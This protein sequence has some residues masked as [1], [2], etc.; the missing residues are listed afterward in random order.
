MPNENK[1]DLA[2]DL[3]ICEAATVG[4]WAWADGKREYND[5]GRVTSP[6]GDVCNF[7]N[8]ARYYPTAGE[9]PSKADATFIAEARTGWPRA[10]ERALAAEDETDLLRDQIGMFEEIN[11]WQAKEIERLRRLLPVTNEQAA[12]QLRLEREGRR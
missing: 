6:E 8:Y 1:R 5:L 4:P 11:A 10:I 7:G 12:E 9:E 3:A 2:A